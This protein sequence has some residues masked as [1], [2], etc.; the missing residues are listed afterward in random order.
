MASAPYFPCRSVNYEQ[1]VSRGHGRKSLILR[2]FGCDLPVH[3]QYMDGKIIQTGEYHEG[4][5]SSFSFAFIFTNLNSKLNSLE[6]IRFHRS[7]PSVRF[8]GAND[9]ESFLKEN[10]TVFWTSS[11]TSVFLYFLVFVQLG[12]DDEHC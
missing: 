8:V 12:I 9:T 3:S 10:I 7:V 2:S 6:A 5:V 4:I 1:S 11:F